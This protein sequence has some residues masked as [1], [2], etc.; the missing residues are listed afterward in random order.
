MRTRIR[1]IRR[2]ELVEATLEVISELG[3]EKA[4]IADISRRAGFSMGYLHHH[5]R[6]KDE[7]LLETKRVYYSDMRQYLIRQIASISDPRRRLG[8]IIDANFRAEQFTPQNAYTWVSFIARV[9]FN[10]SFQRFQNIVTERLRSNL[11]FNLKQLIPNQKAE[12]A[13]DKLITLLHGYWVQ[14]GIDRESIDS[15]TVIQR[16]NQGIDRLLLIESD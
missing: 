8:I 3:F 2:R 15:A 1:D 14:L 9:P 7:I 11:L 12:A 4:T 10:E 5:F 6:N 13:T 16:M